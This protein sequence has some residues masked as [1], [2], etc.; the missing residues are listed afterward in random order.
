MSKNLLLVFTLF[1]WISH[2]AQTVGIGTS[3]PHSS[4]MLDISSNTKGLLIP[5]LTK[6][7]K[8]AIGN[9]ATGL[10]V[11]QT[12]P[13]SSG[14]H[15]YNGSQWIWIN[16]NMVSGAALPASAIVL[17]ETAT[18][19]ALLT[20][21]YSY[22][23]LLRLPGATVEQT[24]PAPANTWLS[25]NT[26][27]APPAASG[28]M[29]LFNDSVFYVWGGN[30][31]TQNPGTGVYKY[32][33]AA[34][35]WTSMNTTGTSP[36][37]G[38]AAV[39]VGNKWVHWGGYTYPG[40]GGPPAVVYD[41][42][43]NT[44]TNTAIAPTGTG[45]A[46][47]AATTGNNKAY[48]FGGYNLNNFSIIVNQGFI[49]NTQNNTWQIMSTT[50]APAERY[51]AGMV[52]TNSHVMVWGGYRSNG[53]TNTGGLYDTTTNTWTSV[54]TTNAPTGSIDPI[55]VWRSPY[56]YVI[57]GNM[58]K[59]YDPVANIW[60]NLAAAPTVFSGNKFAYD[61]SGKI[62]IWGGTRVFFAPS[63]TANGY[64]YDIVANTF[65]ALP[66]V[67]APEARGDHTLSYGSNMLLAWGGTT[68]N[69]PN[70]PTLAQSLNTGGR[71]L[72]APAIVTNA[73]P[74]PVWHLFKKQ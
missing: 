72:L 17:S 62:Y 41:L 74:A 28:H 4:A 24:G 61:G 54:S 53:T 55:M 46:G 40:L 30:A 21:G 33:P 7:E 47:V 6:A 45:L 71:F 70:T 11:Y 32:S 69:S 43:A 14:F 35:R 15:Y 60:T 12:G 19:N 65:T 29:A 73:A 13:D 50:D 44:V 67:G 25:T 1:T 26:V 5:R 56:V 37:L 8:E 64:V 57:S 58:A 27:P 38:T 20:A 48:F 42:V 31:G 9:A 68:N 16:P 51:Y 63:P 10:M 59:R 39:K 22:N 49:Y 23:G 18:N 52:H 36:A 66:L 34:D 2:K 3:S